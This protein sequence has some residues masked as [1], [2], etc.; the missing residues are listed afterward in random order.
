MFASSTFTPATI[1]V[2]AISLLTFFDDDLPDNLTLHDRSLD[3]IEGD[4][5]VV[6]FSLVAFF[7]QHGAD[8]VSCDEWQFAQR[9][10]VDV[11]FLDFLT[12]FEDQV[13]F[14]VREAVVL[15][16][17]ARFPRCVVGTSVHP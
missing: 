3:F 8:V 14:V 17:F 13:G 10:F 7:H 2:F 6:G 15:K 5:L 1:S 12:G 9:A 16:L 11:D 4:R